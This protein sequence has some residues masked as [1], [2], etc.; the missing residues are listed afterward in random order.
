MADNDQARI[1][2]GGTSSNAGYLE[3]ATADDGTEPIYVRQYTGVFSSL[4]RTLTLLDESGN[5]NFP[6]SIQ[7]NANGIK[8]DESG[9]RSWNMFPSSGGLRITSGDGAG[10]LDVTM[11]GGI[12]SPIY[13]DYNDTAYYVNPAGSSFLGNNLGLVRGAHLYYERSSGVSV[14][15]MGWHTDDIFYVAGHPGYGP[16]AGNTVRIYGFGTNLQLG[17]ANYGDVL[18]VGGG[19]TQGA[20]SI[21][22]PIFYDSDNTAYYA[23]PA[24]TSVF[25]ALTLGGYTAESRYTTRNGYWRWIRY[26]GYVAP[27]GGAVVDWESYFKTYFYN[28][29]SSTDSSYPIQDSNYIST[30]DSVGTTGIFGGSTGGNMFGDLSSYHCHIYTNIYVERQFTVSSVNLN[31]DDPFALFIDGVFVTGATSCCTN[32]PYSYTF[33]PGWHRLDLIYSEG[34]GGDYVQLGWNPKDYSQI[35]MVTPYMAGESALY[36]ASIPYTSGN[37]DKNAPYR[38][39]ND[40]SGWVE[41]LAGVPGAGNGWGTFWA[42]NDS[43]A[44]SYF[45]TSNPNEYVF[46][47]AGGVRASIDLDNGDSYFAGSVR[48][49]IFYDS[50]NT[51]YYLDPNSTT[52][53]KTVGSWRSDSSTW[54]GEFSGKMQ[55]H[56]NHWYI[57]AAD[58]LIYRNSGGSNVFT[59]NQSGDTTASSSSRAPIFY[60][61]NNTGYFVDPASA[62]NFN[63]IYING[64]SA[65]AFG[66]YWA[67]GGGYPGYQFS[68]GDGRFGFSSTGGVLNV[69][70]D[71]NFYATDSSH[72]VLHD[73]NAPRGRNSSLM[74]Y[75]GFT[76]NANDMPDN[77]TGFTYSVNAPTTGPIVRFSTGGGYDMW[78]NAA[79][80]GGNHLHF[81]TRNGDAGS[82]NAW[83]VIPSYGI[84]YA[85][86]LFASIFY[87][88]NNTGYYADFASTAADCAIFAGGIHVSKGNVTGQGIILADDGDIVDLNDGY[89]AMRFSSGVRIHSANRGGSATIRLGN[90]GNIIA[91][92]NI[93]A[94]G[95]ASDRRLKENVKPLVGALDKIMQLQGCTFDWKE[96]TD[97]RDLIGIKE[98]IGFIADEVQAVVP[99]MVRT[100]VEGYLSLRDRGF[101]ALLVEAVKEQQKEIDELKALVKQLLEKK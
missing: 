100:D 32:V 29:T 61:S 7:T 46:V 64:T 85:D 97:Q 21:R 47:G 59:V 94:Y 65:N 31:G 12:R 101:S 50:N 71:G 36:Q 41:M 26:A 72:L 28:R 37:G 82:I 11:S 13:Y 99:E 80:T 83:R 68:G 49:P 35:T 30:Y 73:G 67:G 20:G 55:Y 2:V 96:N 1:L 86:S 84:S 3:I 45:G 63:T 6:G 9:V 89:C 34:G 79:Y 69:Y 42:G 74:Y 16:G 23:N 5:S 14:G 62:S 75:A 39:N 33:Y 17:N 19:Y 57:Q 95:S 40:Y 18:T 38:F 52:S 51:A 4:T 66:S 77:T 8:W 44:Y 43:P 91:N 93:T 58:L 90:G 27:A 78:L 92:D 48:S 98:D 70:A 53:L 10:Y 54:D 76:L 60:D 24:G 25:N 56:S 87:D 15:A 88:A 22:A 81:R